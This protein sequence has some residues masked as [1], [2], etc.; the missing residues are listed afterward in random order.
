MGWEINN[1][2]PTFCLFF[3]SGVTVQEGDIEVSDMWNQ[4]S[5]IGIEPFKYYRKPIS[6]IPNDEEYATIFCQPQY[7]Q[8]EITNQAN[9]NILGKFSFPTDTRYASEGYKYFVGPIQEVQRLIGGDPKDP[10]SYPGVEAAGTLND[11]LPPI[12]LGIE[13]EF[14][15][16]VHK[17]H[18]AS[19]VQKRIIATTI[20][21]IQRLPIGKDFSLSGLIS[22]AQF[23]VGVNSIVIT[24][25]A[26]G[27]NDGTPPVDGVVRLSPS[28]KVVI[29][30]LDITFVGGS[31]S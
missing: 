6:I 2:E 15:L 19:Q 10:I 17:G 28:Q 9:I 26:L 24:K 4:L 13:I 23:V 11:V 22:S 30:E 27:Y 20:S 21:Y 7:N 14:N 18:I 29:S 25:I 5:I 31:L 12:P 3:T 8:L 1:N 16:I